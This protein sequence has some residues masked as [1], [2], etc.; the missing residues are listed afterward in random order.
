MNLPT[1]QAVASWLTASGQFADAVILKGQSDEEV[2]ND[3]VVIYV[4]C[5]NTDTSAPSLYLASVR[6]ILSSPA[7]IDGSLDAHRAICLSLRAILKNAAGMVPYFTNQYLKCCG[8]VL[9][10]WADSQDNQR[11]LSQ[12]NLTIGI[13]DLLA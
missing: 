4:A 6:I 11:W 13:V 1:E 8:A 9:N 7:V 10:N 12:A 5:E 2:P 3:K